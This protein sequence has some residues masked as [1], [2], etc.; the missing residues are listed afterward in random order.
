MTGDPRAEMEVDGARGTKSVTYPPKEEVANVVTHGLGL[1]LSLVGLA[2]LLTKAIP[3]GNPWKIS[4]L[5]VYGATLVGVYL[6]STLY[7]SSRKKQTKTVFRI[8]DHCA[9]YLLIAGTYTPFLLV[10]LR[11]RLGWS[12]FGVVWG[13]ALGGVVFKTFFIATF[14]KME[15][16][17]YVVMG[18]LSV[19]ALRQLIQQITLQGVLWIILGG[20]VYMLGLPALGWHRLS[21]NHAIWHVFVL[22]GGVLHFIAI[23]L[24]IL[25]AG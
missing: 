11:S 5:A 23:S 24:Y 1:I 20:V 10:A 8:L 15:S 18:W 6:A 4:S 22:G 14:P 12:L 21:Y 17:T 25:P 2:W 13:L 3:G 19:V 16:A 7:H 9:I